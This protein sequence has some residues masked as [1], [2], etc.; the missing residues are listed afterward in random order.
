MV[1]TDFDPQVI[2]H[3][4]AKTQAKAA[5]ML[6]KRLDN[7]PRFWY[8]DRGRACDG[9]P[10]GAFDYRHARGD[11]WPPPGIDWFVWAV[12]SGR[13]GGKTRSAGE[14]MRKMSKHWPRIAGIG[15]RGTDI[16][17]TMVEGESGLIRICEQAGVEYD[18]KPSVKEFTF[19][20]GSTIYFYSAE[21]PDALRGP[22]HHAA[23][24]DEPAHMPLIQEVWDNLLMGLR[25]G[26]APKIMVTTT[27]LPIDWMKTL[28][29]EPDT[30]VTRVSTY[31]NIKNLSP[32]FRKNVLQ[33]YEGTRLGRQEIHGEVLEDV[34]GALWTS[35]MVVEAAMNFDRAL[36]TGLPYSGYDGRDFDY[37]VVGVDPA[38]SS[39]KR[40]DETGIVVVA[41]LGDHYFVL[42]DL[43]GNYTPDQWSKKAVDAYKKWGA[44]K[45][46]AE[47]NYGGEMVLST[48]KARSETASVALVTSR[49]GKLIRA[50]PIVMLY[51]QKRVS[52]VG[53]LKD[54]EKQQTEWVPERSDSPDR[55]DA[56]VHAITYMMKKSGQSQLGHAPKGVQITRSPSAARRQAATTI[57]VYRRKRSTVR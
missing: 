42:E 54:L 5:A 55:I 50:E 16:R 48:L 18:W 4:D 40:A 20:N 15:R 34:E 56:E 17:A 47:K 14:Y 51:E 43:S 38:G 12:V 49:R 23:W 44:N 45:I 37:V 3:W 41:R 1:D 29:K 24:L 9:E 46:V 10:H 39:A 7:P 28:I 25:L 57:P 11:Q 31:A 2:Q 8:C 52:H 53:E 30:R 21:E 33:K 19:E 26:S 13:G 22:Q 36:L 6:K 35:G 32:V 27:P